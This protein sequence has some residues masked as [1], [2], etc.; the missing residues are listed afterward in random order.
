MRK[1]EGKT[2]GQEK[3]LRVLVCFETG[4]GSMVAG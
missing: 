4:E 1:E 2:Q 3:G